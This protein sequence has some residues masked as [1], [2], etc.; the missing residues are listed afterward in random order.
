METCV[1]TK[2]LWKLWGEMGTEPVGSP[3]RK[4]WV[5][6]E[7]GGRFTGDEGKSHVFLKERTKGGIQKT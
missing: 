3:G 2:A 4:R 5:A 1:S 7:R 6:G